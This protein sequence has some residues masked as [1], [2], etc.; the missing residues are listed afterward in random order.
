MKTQ[1][2]KIL[3]FLIALIG[4]SFQTNAQK[5]NL[6]ECIQYALDNNI[7]LQ[8]TEI[9]TQV[10]DYNAKNNKYN[11]LPTVNGNAG[12]TNNFGRS[13]DPFTN[14]FINANVVSYNFSLNSQVTL[15]NGFTKVNTMKQSQID[16][17]KSILDLQKSKNDLILAVSSTYLQVLMAKENLKKNE[18]QLENSKEQQARIQKQYDAGALPMSNLLEIKTQVANDEFNKVSAE[19]QLEIA[20]LNLSQ[21]LDIDS[22]NFDVSEPELNVNNLAIQNYNESELF[23][24]ANQTL[25]E[26]KSAEL[27]VESSNTDLKVSKGR[28]SPSLT[29]SAVVF[30][31]TSSTAPNPNFTIESSLDTIGFTTS[32]DEVIIPSFNRSFPDNYIFSDQ[33]KDNIRQQVSLNLS[34]PIFNG[35]NTRTQVQRSKLNNEI[36]ELNAQNTKNQLKKDVQ[37]AYTDY[38]L[39]AKR[40][41]SAQNQLKVAEENYKNAK[42]RFEQGLISTTDYRTILNA[43][44]SAESDLLNAKYDFVFKQ[45]ILDCYQGKEMKL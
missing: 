29:L 15:F 18:L 42:I 30:T 28:Y 12:V 24:A 23:E 37:K 13:V 5:M 3:F 25:P 45:K 2:Y 20:L 32:G 33:L 39:A 8:Q 22:N 43:K 19:N 9:N 11:L 7:Q 21:L 41:K 36:A 1:K 44:N 14:Q 6:E 35:M 17:Q 4:I 34:I 16:Y 40:Y 31:G 38:N 10:A 26:I 27:G